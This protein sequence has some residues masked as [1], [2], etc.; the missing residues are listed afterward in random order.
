MKVNYLINNKKKNLDMIPYF[1]C[2]FQLWDPYIFHHFLKINLL[3]IDNDSEKQK[4]ARK[5]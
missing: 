3:P 5:T 4:V 1:Q 2:L